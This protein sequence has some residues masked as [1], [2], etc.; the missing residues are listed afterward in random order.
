MNEVKLKKM[1]VRS[2]K[3]GFGACVAIFIATTLGM[4]YAASAGT[5]TLL[6]I[7][8]T[9]WE[10]LRLSLY[11]II[12]FV[13]SVAVAGILFEHINQQ[14][15][16]FGLFVFIIAFI[17]ELFGWRAALSVNAVIGTHFLISRDFSREA[18]INEF[19]LVIIGSAGAVILNLFN[20]NRSHKK[21]IVQNMRDTERDLQIVLKE[22]A[23]Y[24]DNRE[25]KR[26][27]WEDLKLLEEN[28]EHYTDEAYIY[29]GN[30][31]HSHP[32]YYIDYFKMRTWQCH[33][34]QNLHSELQRIREMP[35]QAKIVSEYMF[36][37]ADFVT[38]ANVPEKQIQ[39]LSR[40]F[41]RM[42]LQ[43]L[44]TSR[45]EF[46]S[47]AT[48]YHILMDLEDF[49]LFKKQ[50]VESLSEVQKQKYWEKKIG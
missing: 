49:L 5:I 46:E 44:P 4:E 32:G 43:P 21:R 11:R 39:A 19:C 16:A 41:A 34:L 15:L 8:T 12:T 47:R 38:E 28:L 29:Q 3:V 27:V 1:L 22:L 14:W 31:F 10:T 48:L 9:K 7:L 45:E 20:G 6:T 23:Q 25:M 37:M 17:C 30:T 26:D 13:I 40:I 50:F 33:M 24:L 35:V 42:Q 2:F 36:Y 18:I